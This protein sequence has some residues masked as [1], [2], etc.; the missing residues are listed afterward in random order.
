MQNCA[1]VLRRQ[2]HYCPLRITCGKS[3]VVVGKYLNLNDTG[4]YEDNWVGY[5]AVR[6]CILQCFFPLD[7]QK[8]ILIAHFADGVSLMAAPYN[9]RA[10][11]YAHKHSAP[12]GEWATYILSHP[13]EAWNSARIFVSTTP[14]LFAKTHLAINCISIYFGVDVVSISSSPTR[15]DDHL[16]LLVCRAGCQWHVMVCN[17]PLPCFL[18]DTSEVTSLEYPTR[19]FC[20]EMNVRIKRSYNPY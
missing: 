15:I 14:N 16:H 4:Y 19:W 3:P 17:L 5:S 1:S 9:W 18:G 12:T 11:S 10:W 8:L 6:D 20:T 7:S 2:F 13:S